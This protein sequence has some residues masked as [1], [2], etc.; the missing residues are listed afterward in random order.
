MNNPTYQEALNWASSHIVTKKIDTTAPEFI[1]TQ[2]HNWT[3]TDLL[4]N[5]QAVMPNSEWLMFQRD[6][7]RLNNFEPAQYIAGHTP[8]Y[9]N[10][11]TVTPA[12]LI[13]ESETEE[14]VEWVLTEF[15]AVPA[16][17]VLDLGTGSGVIGITLKL[18]RPDWQVM[19]SDISTAALTVARENAQQ[20]NAEVEFIASDLFTNIKD[21]FDLIVANPPYI[22][23]EEIELL[24]PQVLKFE[25][26]M[27][28]FAEQHGMEFYYQLLAQIDRFLRV[29]GHL[30]GEIGYQQEDLIKQAVE[31]RYSTARIDIKRDISGKP[32]MFHAWKFV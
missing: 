29:D 15:A 12:V 19:A 17:R 32:R 18:Q 8:F 3:T 23:T 20:L 5:R 25:P 28:L 22:G 1:L 31:T 10:N 27:A 26:K 30:F 7:G 13:P 16:L 4:M 24:D 14:L 6:I 21:R 9:G 11:F 2:R